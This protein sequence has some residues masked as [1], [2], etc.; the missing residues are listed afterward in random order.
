MDEQR[1]DTIEPLE[2]GDD[3]VAAAMVP[4]ARALRAWFAGDVGAQ[5]L[6]RRDDG[7]EYP[8]P[9]GHFFRSESEMPA[10]ELAALE[11]CRGKVLDVGAGVGADSLILQA[12]GVDVL[13]IDI[14]PIAVEIMQRRGV[15]NALCADVFA[16]GGEQFDTMLLM[17]HGLGIV[18]DPAGLDRFLGHARTLLRPGGAIVL[19]SLDVTRTDDPVHLAYHQRNLQAGLDI[20]QT[21]LQFEFAGE[22][23]PYCGWLNVLPA[24]LRVHAERAG[25]S[26]EILRVEDSGDYL[27]RLE[28]REGKGNG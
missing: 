15:R 13:A 18:G 14:S 16:F 3:D 27:A 22:H 17:G 1:Q 19:D 25:L 12:R 9:P 10:L 23:G 7:Q 8:L 4:Y 26:C 20:G 21:R 2:R 11:L 6:M 24:A 28:L 5:L